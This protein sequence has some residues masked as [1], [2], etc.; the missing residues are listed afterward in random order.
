[1]HDAAFLFDAIAL[2]GAA[3]FVVPLFQRFRIP[4]VLGYLVAGAML[5]PHTPG[6]VIDAALPQVLAEFGVVFLLFSIG[7]E[8]PLSRLQ[9]MR[10]FIFGLGVLQVAA[11]AGVIG[12]VAYASGLSPEAALVI[13][14]T[15]SFS[16]T[17]TVLTLLVERG[18]TMARYGRVAIAVLIFQDL[19]VV[20][21]LTLLPLLSGENAASIPAAL[22]LAGLKGIGA[23]AVILVLGRFVVRPIY[24]YVAAVKSPEVFT[25]TNLFIVLLIGW[26]TAQVGMSMALGA[27]LAGLVI[28]DTAYRHQVEAD[29]EPFRGLLLGLFF[30]TVGMALDLPLIGRNVFLIAALTA[31]LLAGKALI[32]AALARLVGLGIANALRVGLV[33]AQGGEFAFVVIGKAMGL[34][35]LDGETG[36]IL[37]SVVAISMAVTPA[38]AACAHHAARWHEDRWG[39]ERFGLETGDLKGHVLIAGYGRVGRAVARILTAHDIPY[40][41]L[42][43]DTQRVAKARERA[44][45][46]YYADASQAGVLRAAGI[47]RARSAVVTVNRPSVAERTV[48]GI[49]RHAPALDI[50]VRAHDLGQCP[51]L[52]AAGATAVVPEA[53]EASLQL[54]GLVLR[55]TG[56]P[57][58]AVERGLDA[59]RQD[60]YALLADNAPIKRMPGGAD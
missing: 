48:A 47:E 33:L 59:F 57:A 2:L 41:A 7:L 13:G 20:P 10:R 19:A 58:E 37:L 18:E 44:L 49:R 31:A 29:I 35:L 50:V 30:M 23:I 56:L 43:Q 6:P 38:L 27:F 28:A 24:Q 21:V 11:T 53:M 14:A 45:P 15:L 51:V 17:A 5:G 36:Q 54:A 55:S 60:N 3:I 52:E 34:D 22:A 16:S 40:V 25:A 4:A 9:A 8:L 26:G 42:D 1:M 39:K 12:L 32:L 46:V